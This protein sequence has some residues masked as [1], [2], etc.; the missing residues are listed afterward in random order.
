MLACN[1]SG[2]LS[3]WRRQGAI[4]DA[5]KDPDGDHRALVEEI[6]Q[7]V[8]AEKPDEITYLGNLLIPIGAYDLQPYPLVMWEKAYA[9]YRRSP[10]FSQYIRQTGAFDYWRQHGYPSQCRPLGADDFECD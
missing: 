5:Y 4:Y 9:G 3:G 8:A 1:Q 2:W 7:F 6:L 10:Q